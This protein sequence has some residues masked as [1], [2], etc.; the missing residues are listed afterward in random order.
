MWVHSYCYN[1]DDGEKKL[2]L[3][4]YKATYFIYNTY[5]CYVNTIKDQIIRQFYHDFYNLKTSDAYITK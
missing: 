4:K 1:E 3:S 5:F 2:A